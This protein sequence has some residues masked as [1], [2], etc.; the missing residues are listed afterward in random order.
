MC[1]FYEQRSSKIVSL[2]LKNDQARVVRLVK[3]LLIKLW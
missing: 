1:T 2:N 3:D